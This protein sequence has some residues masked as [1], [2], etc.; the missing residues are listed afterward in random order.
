MLPGRFVPWLEQ[1]PC[2]YDLGNWIMEQAL[3]DGVL[4]VRRHP[5]PPASQRERR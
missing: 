5:T 3:A 4:M 1:D 2:F